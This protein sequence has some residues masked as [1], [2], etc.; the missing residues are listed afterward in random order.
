MKTRI[1]FVPH[2]PHFGG[3]EK[4]LIELVRSFAGQQDCVVWYDPVDF[5]SAGFQ[6]WPNVQVL[7]RP[8]RINN[9]SIL[10]FWIEL[11]RL[12]P[13]V[14]VFV[15]G[16]ADIYPWSS[17]LAARLSGA[18]RVVA[19]DHLIADPAPAPVLQG[20]IKG[21]ARRQF[22]WQ[23]R[24]MFGKWL[25]GNLVDITVA[26]S[27]AVRH[28]L[29]REYRYPAE[30]TVT[31]YNGIDL[32]SFSDGTI[33]Q[34]RSVDACDS[35]A[36]QTVGIICV[37]RL[38]PVKRIDVLLEALAFLVE[39]GKN[40]TC[41]IVGGGPLESELVKKAQSLGLASRVRFTGHV[42]N[43]RPYM[44][45]ADLAVLSSDKEG[46][47]LSL[48]EAMACGLPCVV[49]DVGGNREVVQHG[50]TGLVVEAG[51][52]KQLADAIAYLLDNSEERRSMGQAARCS[53]YERFNLTRMTEE[54]KTLLL[55]QFYSP[56]PPDPVVPMRQTTWM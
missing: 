35:T 15:K 5:Y 3:A 11:I 34:G 9:R 52:P 55:P 30:K 4:H 46:L 33:R 38:S 25:Q 31:I 48:V 51:S 53:A 14:V 26:V 44:E 37:A 40:W 6:G 22:G 42:E 17:Y 8:Y 36:D 39:M 49:T 56:E 2:S 13:H 20:G 16:I 43:V 54:Y 28:R 50:I 24:Y 32:T 41:T 1:V 45:A 47:P 18:E 19:I 23:R 29:V 7:L 10:R 21:F 27:E 12:K